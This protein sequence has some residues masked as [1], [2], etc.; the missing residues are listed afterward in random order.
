MEFKGK[1]AV[2]TGG[3]SGI[4]KAT[5]MELARN[6]AR[7]ICADINEAA[8]RALAEEA[9]RGGL[10]IEYEPIDLTDSASVRRC[11]KAVTARHPKIDTL[12]NA[13]GFSAGHPLVEM[14]PDYL[15]KVDACKLS[16]AL[17]LI[18]GVRP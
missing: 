5:V 8:G 13:A 16:G 9:G 2:V 17:D 3:A 12:V 7:V 18:E 11:A 1:I 10:A 15:H 4:G 14:V 6:G